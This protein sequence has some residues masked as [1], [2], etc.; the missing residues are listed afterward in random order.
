[1][2]GY[3]LINPLDPDIFLHC[4][5]ADVAHYEGRTMTDRQQHLFD[6]ILFSEGFEAAYAFLL[7][8]V[9][10]NRQEMK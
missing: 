3:D 2:A 6:W 5:A 1:M 7:A 10:V 4:A 9:A 8:C